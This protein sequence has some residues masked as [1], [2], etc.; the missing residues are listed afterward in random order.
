MEFFE[1]TIADSTG[2]GLHEEDLERISDPFEHVA[3]S[4][5]RIFE[6]TGLR[7]A[8]AREFVE[9][10]GGRIWAESQGLGRGSS[11]HFVISVSQPL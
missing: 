3:S 2:E 6:G 10:H 7:L 9:L 5:A 11:F 1:V 4:G 8:L